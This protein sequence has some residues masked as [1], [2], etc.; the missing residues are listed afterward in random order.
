MKQVWV[1]LSWLV[2]PHQWGHQ[3]KHRPVIPRTTVQ[4]LNEAEYS[5]LGPSPA[6]PQ[7]V[8]WSWIGG[9]PDFP[10]C[11]WKNQQGDSV[12]PVA[13]SS[14]DIWHFPL[15]PIPGLENC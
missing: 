8:A 2:E 12:V 11:I 9:N 5:A 7:L 4:S 13:P 10:D 3:C 6:F 15:K 1:C 14:S